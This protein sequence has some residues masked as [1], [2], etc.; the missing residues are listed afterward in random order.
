MPHPELTITTTIDTTSISL[1]D[2]I[3]ALQG[4]ARAID[5]TT[6]RVAVTQSGGD[7]PFDRST[8]SIRISGKSAVRPGGALRDH[9]EDH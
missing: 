2:L 3:A 9:R 8:S 5:P 7:R 1:S 4:A 6:A